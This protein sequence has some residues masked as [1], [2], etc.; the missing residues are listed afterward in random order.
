MILGQSSFLSLWLYSWTNKTATH[1]LKELAEQGSDIRIILE[2][3]QYRQYSDAFGDFADIFSG[4]DNVS[5]QSDRHLGTNFNHTKTFINDSR[6]SIQTANVT[7]SAFTSNREHFFLTQNET[8]R[9]NLLS[10]FN[11]DRS[12]TPLIPSDIHPNLLVCPIDCRDKL[13]TLLSSS[14]DQIR[15]MHQ[16]MT[17]DTLQDIIKTKKQY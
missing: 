5:I 12:G 10:L 15:M 16:Y 2:D 7:H 3:K 6:V 4:Y 8:I 14:Q 11:K 13:I 17:D 1:H 9:Q